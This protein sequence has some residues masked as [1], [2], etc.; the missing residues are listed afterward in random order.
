LLSG[1]TVTLYYICNICVTKNV[2]YF[3]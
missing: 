1:F 3:A 2:S